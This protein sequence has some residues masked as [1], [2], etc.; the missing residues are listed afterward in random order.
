MKEGFTKITSN[1][2]INDTFNRGE[3]IFCLNRIDGVY[4]IVCG[5]ND[6]GNFLVVGISKPGELFEYE[7]DLGQDED[8]MVNLI[9]DHFRWS[10][11]V[12]N[13]DYSGM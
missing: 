3:F 10:Y 12:D 6:V 2:E 9:P 8:G 4:A 11:Y 1:V 13:G 5:Q 7:F